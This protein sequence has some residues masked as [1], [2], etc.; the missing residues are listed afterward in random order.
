MDTPT[1]SNTTPK[2]TKPPRSL[3]RRIAEETIAA[4]EYGSYTIPGPDSHV[5]HDLTAK[6]D[7]SKTGTT[8]YP[9]D[10]QILSSWSNLGFQPALNAQTNVEILE[11][12]TIEGARLLYDTLSSKG[13]NERI[14]ILNFA[15]AKSVSCIILFRQTSLEFNSPSAW[16]RFPGWLPRT[17]RIT[18]PFFDSLSFPNIARRCALLHFAQT[19]AKRRVLLPRS[20]LFALCSLH[21]H[22]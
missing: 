2:R 20:Y 15:S 12:S 14:G 10:S 19:R 16:R 18:R 22:R 8:Y 17:R 13:L 5:V 1:T 21:S 3:V 4:I 11:I 7:V 6:I 9:A